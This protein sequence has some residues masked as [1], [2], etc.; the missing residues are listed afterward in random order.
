MSKKI[1]LKKPLEALIISSFH[2]EHL[3]S[4]AFGSE[5]LKR[6]IIPPKNNSF[7]EE[8]EPLGFFF[9]HLDSVLPHPVFPGW[10]CSAER[11]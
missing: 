5:V 2:R 11:Q 7:G 10:R 6:S 8:V 4:P 3:Q 1:N 9:P